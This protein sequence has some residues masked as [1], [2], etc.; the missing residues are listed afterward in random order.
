MRRTLEAFVV[1]SLLAATASVR[2]APR[3][4]LD[5]VNVQ[6]LPDLA[7]GFTAQDSDGA[8][9]AGLR[10]Q[11]L[12]F[13][14]DGEPL[15][16]LAILPAA[17][18]NG[19][20]VLFV[21]E[22]S[23]RLRGPEFFQVRNLVAE[24]TDRLPPE[25]RAAL[26]L[27][28]ASVSIPIRLTDDHARLKNALAELTLGG[29]AVSVFTA[30]SRALAILRDAPESRREIVL[31]ASG[32]DVADA[33]LRDNVIALARQLH[34]PI[35]VFAAGLRFESPMLSTLAG[36]TGGRYYPEPVSANAVDLARFA[37]AG[38][39]GR[40]SAGIHLNGPLDGR[41]T[42]AVLELATNG[43]TAIAEFSFLLTRGPG[44]SA[45]AIQEYDRR[46]SARQSWWFVYFGAIAGALVCVL[47]REA[48]RLRYVLARLLLLGL[49]L[50]GGGFV[51]FVLS[52]LGMP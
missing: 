52:R 38:G 2:G 8:E 12:R 51:G 14:L 19:A 5:A 20:A 21:M 25:D 40:Y 29:N 31:L 36:E 11:D 22:I 50:A 44:I 46:A 33:S 30:L 26:V 42:H 6:R 34:V 32:E 45:D 41:P 4:L 43:E 15:P 39:V 48:L 7:F 17:R 49:G 47:L 10:S 9:I 37:L 27:A 24:L 18:Q 13:L 16:G 1:F 28:S 3:L 35:H 23:A